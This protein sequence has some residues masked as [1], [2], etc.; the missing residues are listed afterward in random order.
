MYFHSKFVILIYN[1]NIYTILRKILVNSPL[2]HR[3][4]NLLYSSY[5]QPM[6]STV[7]LPKVI[8]PTF[9]PALERIILEFLGL[10]S[11]INSNAVSIHIFY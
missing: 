8:H 2:T 4:T 11:L 6:V 5:F 9:L 7:Y 10:S 3:A 1:I